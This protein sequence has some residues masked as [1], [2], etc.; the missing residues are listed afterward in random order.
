MAFSN[1]V[2]LAI[3]VTTAATLHVV[4]I[5]NIETSS[6]AAEALKPIA[7][8]FAF[9]VVALGIFG[10]GLLA[11]PVLAGSAASAVGEAFRW[12]IGLAR[13]PREAKAFYATILFATMIGIGMNFLELSPHQGAFLERGSQ[14]NCRPAGHGDHDDYDGQPHDHGKIPVSGMLKLLGWAA[15][16]VMTAAV[17]GMSITA[18]MGSGIK[19][20]MLHV[21]P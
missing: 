7:G 20:Y 6:Q 2:A 5:T 14:R 18:S 11:V 15:T 19:V 1:L 17:V 16:F 9:A 21:M 12:P 4:G 10:I 8:N 3:I 13:Q